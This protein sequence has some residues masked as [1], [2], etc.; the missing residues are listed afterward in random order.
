MKDLYELCGITKQSLHKHL[1]KQSDLDVLVESVVQKALKIRK[2]H[3]QLGCRSIYRLLSDSG[4]GRDKCE[5]LLLKQGFRIKRVR[6]YVKTT[7]SQKHLKF[8]NLI[9][10]LE[11][12][13]I[14]QVWQ[15]DLTYFITPNCGVFYLVFILDIYSRRIIGFT[16]NNHMRAEA[17]L[18][19]LAMAI[20]TRTKT[21]ISGVIHHS[22]YGSQY[23]SDDYL[24][25]LELIKAQV[26]MSKFA[27]KNAY[28]E[29]INGTVKND[30]L[31]HR[32]IASLADL[33]YH[34]RRD[35]RAY[36]E[37]RP[38]KALPQQMSPVQFEKY[39]Q[40]VPTDRHPK[41]KIYDENQ[42]KN[43]SGLPPTQS[44]ME[45]LFRFP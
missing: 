22:D 41:F 1:S 39:L 40:A 17:N 6:S 14:N 24:D 26:S 2:V 34:L 20:K 42:E 19:C 36:N 38:H 29:R 12:Q 31:M 13:R 18:A 37:E 7:V 5:Q 16:A 9:E 27:W 8:S 45:T 23:G 21:L 43:R 4:L 30:Y 35:I 15:S 10:G 28:A 25:A 11:V 44:T 33:R 3:P 32:K